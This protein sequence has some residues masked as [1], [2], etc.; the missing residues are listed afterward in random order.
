MSAAA[1]Q[2]V[3]DQ[4]KRNARPWPSHL[5]ALLK[6]TDAQVVDFEQDDVLVDGGGIR[7]GAHAP[8]VRRELVTVGQFADRG[9]AQYERR[10]EHAESEA[11][12]EFS[13]H[14][15]V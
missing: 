7:D 5:V 12:R 10:G 4:A 14:A 11:G 15:V 9:E 13:E 2:E 6:L 3:H 1:M 8:V